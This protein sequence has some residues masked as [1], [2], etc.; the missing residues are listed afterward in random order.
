MEF[1]I[2]ISEHQLIKE[3]SIHKLDA[4]QQEMFDEVAC[5]PNFRFSKGW[6]CISFSVF[7]IMK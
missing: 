5:F 4:M 2:V 6:F 7:F 1:L 3:G